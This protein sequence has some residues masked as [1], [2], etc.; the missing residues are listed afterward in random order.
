MG[1]GNV[2]VTATLFFFFQLDLEKQ[3]YIVPV[4]E[5]QLICF[6]NHLKYIPDI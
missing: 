5:S 4:T 6:L 3:K 2:G 1:I